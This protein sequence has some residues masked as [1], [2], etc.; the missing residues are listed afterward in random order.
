MFTRFPFAMFLLTKLRSTVGG[1]RCDPDDAWVAANE[2]ESETRAESDLDPHREQT[3]DE[4]AHETGLPV[5]TVRMYQNK[6]LLPAPVRRGRVGYYGANHRTRLRAIA[7]LQERG[8]SLAAIR[9][10]FE[11]WESGRTVGH[12]IDM[13]DL[14]PELTRTPLRMSMPELLERWEGIP[15]SQDD[16]LRGVELGLITVDGSEVVLR[17]AAFADMGP[18]AARLGIPVSAILDQYELLSAELDEITRRFQGLF[19]ET[20]WEPF[21]AAGMP[22]DQALALTNDVAKL[23]ELAT[24]VVVTELAERFSRLADEYVARAENER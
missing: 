10:V 22:E 24:S 7:S 11:S 16:V 23:A 1:E 15:I 19:E 4:L 6:R 8:F 18:N 17:N 2:A 21:V 5:S 3:I 20:I 12:L 9:E 14:A 13:A